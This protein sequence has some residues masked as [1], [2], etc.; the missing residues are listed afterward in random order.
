MTTELIKA[1]TLTGSMKLF[2]ISCLLKFLFYKQNNLLD[3][4]IG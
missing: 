1:K 4:W 3:D 2:F